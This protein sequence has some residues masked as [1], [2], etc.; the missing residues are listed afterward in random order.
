[1]KLNIFTLLL[2]LGTAW[3]LH[4][5]DN[6]DDESIDVP[7][8][9]QNAFS[10]KYPNAA[11]VKWENKSGYY[12]A[13]F[14]DGYEASAWFTQDGKW[15]MT[16]TDIPYDAL[17][18]AVKTSFETSEYKSW[19]IDDVDKLEREGFETVYVI[20]VENQN[21]EM[22]LYYSVNG[23]LIK[24]VVDTDND[25]DE[26][27]PVQLTDVMKNVINERYPN[28]KIMEVDV[29]N[30]RND[31]DY[32]YTEVDIIHNGISKDVLFNQSGNWYSTSWEVRKNEL[33]DTVNN[34]IDNQYGEYRFDDAKYI[35][36]AD[37]TVYYRI[38]LERGENELTVNIDINGNVI[39]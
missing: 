34:T 3:S 35:E 15:K 26:Y 30:D 12:V 1:M 19:K 7:V 20:E 37:D 33:P 31:W 4:S 18:Q 21:Q 6:N 16:E 23:E 10:S 25:K 2:V 28:A 5:C 32:G 39:Q 24:S 17:P 22:D 8:E 36:K 38:E 13:D 9:L 11:N 27:L 29:E 14:Y